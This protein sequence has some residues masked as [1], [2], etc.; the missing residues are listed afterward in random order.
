M[1]IAGSNTAQYIHEAMLLHLRSSVNTCIPGIIV[2]FDATNQTA[3]VQPAIK[4]RIQID[5]AS[6]EITPDTLITAPVQFPVS[7]AA[8]LAFTIP[9]QK[10]DPCLLLFS[11]RALDNWQTTEGVSSAEDEAEMIRCFD[12][13]DVICIPGVLPLPYKID[14]YSEDH[15]TIR[16]IDNKKQV[17]VGHD[18]VTLKSTDVEFNV[19]YAGRMTGSIDVDGNVRVIG[20]ATGVFTALG[21][22]KVSV[23]EGVVVSIT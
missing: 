14:N 19:D 23:V 12:K 22:K 17:S 15:A 5:D 8:G 18:S 2:S 1:F 9:V 6:Y 21:G 3:S 11:Q 13:V 20:A 4:D 10:D 7:I 16:T